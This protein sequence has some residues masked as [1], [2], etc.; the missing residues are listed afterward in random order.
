[1]TNIV[2]VSK[3]AADVLAE[4]QR[5]VEEEG[6]TAAHDDEH[7]SGDLS[8]AASSYALATAI[9]LA[10]GQPG[11]PYTADNPPEA[12]PPEWEFKPSNPRRMLVKAGALILAEIERLDRMPPIE[13]S[14]SGGDGDGFSG[15]S[16]EPRRDEA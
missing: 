7:Y 15:W 1:M 13:D 8:A 2:A 4:R 3:A 10:P 6:W 16:G 9:L 11:D 14:R 12:W 5:Q